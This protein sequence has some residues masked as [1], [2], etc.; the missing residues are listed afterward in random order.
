MGHFITDK[1][2]VV[3][4]L[5]GSPSTT[6]FSDSGQSIYLALSHFIC[7]TAA[8]RTAAQIITSKNLY[9]MLVNGFLFVSFHLNKSPSVIGLYAN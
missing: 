5:I 8:L 4:E 7:K 3:D 9:K 1:T 2:H 6:L